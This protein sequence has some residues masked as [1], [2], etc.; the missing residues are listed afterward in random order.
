[1]K[2]LN[3]FFNKHECDGCLALIVPWYIVEHND[4]IVGT[5]GC[6]NWMENPKQH[7]HTQCFVIFKKVNMSCIFD[8]KKLNKYLEGFVK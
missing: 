4:Q 3:S 6:L 2:K 1:M 8:K 7:E 5:R